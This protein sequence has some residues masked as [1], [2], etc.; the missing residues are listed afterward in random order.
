MLAETAKYYATGHRKN[1]TAKVWLTPGTG[2][3]TIN[4]KSAAEYLGRK[5]LEMIIRQPLE[6]VEAVGKFDV[7][8]VASGGGISGQAGAIRHGISK[9]IILADPELRPTL[10]RQGYLTRDPRVKERKK[11]GRKRARRGFQFSKR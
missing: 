8:V 11:Y 7:L 5:T 6:V 9:A 10:R 2:S 4:E 1:A 3:I